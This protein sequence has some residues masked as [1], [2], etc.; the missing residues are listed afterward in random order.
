MGRRTTPRGLRASLAVAL[1]LLLVLIGAAGPGRGL[2]GPA[3]LAR[4]AGCAQPAVAPGDSTLAVRVGDA[5]RNAVLHV[6]RRALGRPAALVLAFHGMG[7]SGPFMGRYSGLTPLADRAGF[8]VAYPSAA[9]D[10]R[11]WTL[12]SDAP[13]APDDVAFARAL[14]DRL[15]ARLCVDE[16]RVAAVGVS[17]GG[18]FAARLGCELSDRIVGIVVV[19]GGLDHL[20]P[21]SPLR[22]VSVLEIHG[23]ADQ[24][25]PY[26]GDAGG[27]SSVRGWLAG[28]ARR[29]GCRPTPRAAQRGAVL[30]LVW[31]ACQGGARVDHIALRGGMHQ[32]PG[33][34]PPDPGPRS[35]VSAALEAWRFLAPLR[36]SAAG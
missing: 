35:A 10:P 14:L 33:A 8:L 25:V 5:R 31:E 1:G 11:R 4:S 18:G 21:C 7:G 13:G 34:T 16:R 15:G 22:P 17:N 29:D 12:E 3:P 28:W 27:R 20:P 23:T 36:I 30:R 24:V 32:W 2:A 26:R 6:P 9:G 19:A